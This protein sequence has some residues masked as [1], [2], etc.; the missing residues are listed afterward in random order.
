M[1]KT[2]ILQNKQSLRDNRKW[3]KDKGFTEI[4]LIYR[5]GQ[6]VLTYIDEAVDP[7]I[8]MAT[9][10]IKDKRTKEQKEQMKNMI[11]WL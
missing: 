4:N 11:T 2:I 3:L 7:L 8:L 10:I 6:Y 9:G 5:A 1:Q